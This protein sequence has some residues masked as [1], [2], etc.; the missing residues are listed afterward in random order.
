MA[1]FINLDRRDFLKLSGVAATGLV[2]QASITQDAL[3]QTIPGSGKLAFNVWVTIGTDGR[4]GIIAHRS[5]MGQG[6]RTGL[7]QVVADELDADWRQVDI[8]QAIGD[9]KYINQDTDGSRSVR[10][11]YQ[12]MR[13]MGASARHMLIA[14]AAKQWGVPAAECGTELHKVVHSPSGRSAGF[15]ELAVAA[16]AMP[17]PDVKNLQFKSKD[18]FRYIGKPVP[19]VDME[20]IVTG[21][22]QFGIDVIRPDMVYASIERAPVL[23]SDVVKVNDSA[24]RAVAGVLAVE[25]IGSAAL[26][27]SF[28]VKPGVAVIAT[29]T[30]AAREAR[31]KLNIE[32]SDS[33]HAAFDSHA[34]VAETLKGQWGERKSLVT[35]G[36]PETL[37]AAS[38]ARHTAR[39]SVPHLE[40]ATMEPPAAVAEIADGHCTVW[41]PVQSP[42]RTRDVVAGAIGFDKSKVTVNVTLLGGG[43]GR[44]S[45]PDFAA[46][47]ALLAKKTGR[48]VK[49]TWSREDAI[50]HGY[51]HALSVQEYTAAVDKKGWPEALKVTVAS[52][53]IMSTFAPDPGYMADWEVGQ[54]LT[55]LPWQLKGYQLD[56]AKAAAHTRIGWLRSVYHINHA[57]SANSFA[58]ELARLADVDPLVYQRKLI[59]PDRIIGKA[60]AEHPFSTAR[61]KSALNRVAKSCGWPQKTATN[62][63]WGLAVHGSFHSYVAVAAKVALEGKSLRVTEVHIAADCGQLV[64]PDRVHS[65]MEGAVIFALSHGLYGDIRFEQGRVVNSNFHDYPLL[66]MDKSPRIVVT[67][68][69]SDERPTGVGEPGV[70][71]VIPAVTNAI[72][73]AGGPR[74]R[75]LPINRHLTC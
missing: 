50:Q 5:E 58:D 15:G 2:L 55:N 60:D 6:I 70:P 11:F 51:Y 16:A 59:G 73:D 17:T 26:P 40:H 68:I 3:A 75:Q 54:G 45:K 1:K 38:D 18:Q 48:P 22:S 9:E 61:L 42:V 28:N 31:K 46:E 69:E 67:L 72:V 66:R 10:T 24:A 35:V 7:P 14:A 56:N 12:T 64:N 25:V 13:E 41:A 62:E 4:V 21:K 53:S 20:V 8:I 23:G 44:K 65:Q 19:I 36:E 49:L 74:I 34:F 30:W 29:N 27:P 37:L 52:P 43:F 39:Y 47:A 33:P 32:W 57:F 71:P 63:G